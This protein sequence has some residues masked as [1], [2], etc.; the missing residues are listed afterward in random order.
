[1]LVV[2]DCEN[3]ADLKNMYVENRAAFEA[4]LLDV[5]WLQTQHFF[6]IDGAH[7][8]FLAEL[9]NIPEVQCNVRKYE[10]SGRDA[11]SV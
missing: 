3:D 10:A 9:Y 2:L 1:M 6:I 5:H 8:H 11:V 4:Q 7:R